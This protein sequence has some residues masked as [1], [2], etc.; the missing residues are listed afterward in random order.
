MAARAWDWLDGFPALDLVNTVKR[1]GWQ[2]R[3][4]LED[5]ADLD[6][7]LDVAALPA[8]RPASVDE[9][10]LRALRALRDPALRLLHARLGR[11]EWLP[12][13]V[14]AINAH[15]LAAPELVLLGEHPRETVRHPLGIH[16]VMTRLLAGLAAEVRDATQRCDLAFCDAP[17]CGLVFYRR[18]TN[19]S[20]CGAACGN[21]VRVARHQAG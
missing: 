1:V 8:P 5:P 11:G 15:V 10:D 7:W 9:E 20:W 16:S 13:D 17:G 12:A 4:Q 6:S 21:R 14:K 3:E 19:Q 2:E 18:R